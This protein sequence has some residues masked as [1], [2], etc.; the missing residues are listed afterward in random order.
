MKKKKNPLLTSREMKSYTRQNVMAVYQ[1]PPWTTGTW[2]QQSK[3]NADLTKC[4][5]RMR[6]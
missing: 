2:F 5:E 1:M 6:N 4:V 3:P